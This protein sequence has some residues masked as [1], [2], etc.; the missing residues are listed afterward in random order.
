METAMEQQVDARALVEKGDALLAD[1]QARE[2]AAAYAEAAQLEPGLVGSH[3]GLAEANLALGAYGVVYL[4]CRQVQQLA[5]E[6]A[7]ASLARAILFVLERRFDAAAQ[8]LD[9]VATLDPGRAYAHALRGYCL[10]QLGQSY[11]AQL[12][13]GKARRLSSGKEYAR[14]FPTLQP[15]INGA[16]P[17]PPTPTYVNQQNV[18]TPPTRDWDTASQWQRQQVR[19]RFATRNIPLV[20]YTLIAINVVVYVLTAISV[21]G[22]FYSPA[23]QIQLVGPNGPVSPASGI[24]YYYG[25]QQGLLMQQDPLQWYRLLTAM[26]LHASLAH[27]GLNML[28]L[29]FVGVVTERIFGRGRFALIYFASG[30]IAGL[31]QYFLTSPVE[32]SLGASGAIFGIFGAFGAFI[33]LRREQIRGAGAIIGQWVFFL[34]INLVFSFSSPQIALYDHLGG[35]VSGFL[36]GVLLIPPLFRRA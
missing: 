3:M 10:R 29:Y 28:S 11:D 2:A 27:I 1:G 26:F 13:E 7:D 35:I 5:P 4:A 34:A 20:T 25:V 30:I 15:L 19:M 23:D 16:P 14:L 17:Q 22:N 24:F 18:P 6:S 31:T 33:I 9:R 12:A 36:L 32:P 21:G 8:E